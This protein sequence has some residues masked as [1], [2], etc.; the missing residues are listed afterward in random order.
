MVDIELRTE[1]LAKA[2]A[3]IK[4]RAKCL[5]SYHDL[6][7]TPPLDEMK[8]TVQRQLSAGADVGKLVATA[9]SPEDNM[10]VL[11]LIPAFPRARVVAFAMGGPGLTSRILCPLVGGDF[12]YASIAAGRESAAGQM[13]VASLRKL[14]QMVQNAQ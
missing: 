10:A 4:K 11:E 7:G 2:V 6:K 14:Y 9:L 3:L 1:N 13:T 5:I 8:A 12:T